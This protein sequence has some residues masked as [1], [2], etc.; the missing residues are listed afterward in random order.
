MGVIYAVLFG[1]AF[2]QVSLVAA[3]V[4]QIAAGHY[5]G[6]FV[7]GCAISCLWFVNAKSAAL[8]T[9]PGATAAYTLGAGCGTVTGMFLSRLLLST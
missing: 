8:S 4:A 9:G 7:V 6:A 2:L 3:N 1:R 5:G